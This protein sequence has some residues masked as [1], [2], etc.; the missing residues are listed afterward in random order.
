[1]SIYII[2]DLHLKAAEPE[3]FRQFSVFLQQITNKGNTLYILGDFFEY[4]VGDDANDTFYQR[5]ISLLKNATNCGLV[6]YFM[7]GNRDFLIGKTFAANSGIQLIQDPY[8][9]HWQN[10]LIALM[11][12]DL[13]CTDDQR[14]LRYRKVVQSRWFKW[15]F[16][17]LP[18]ALRNKMADKMRQKSKNRKRYEIEFDATDKGI[19]R[20][21]KDAQII[22]HGHTHKLAIHKHHSKTRYVLGDWHK[23]QYSYI[24]INDQITLYNSGVIEHA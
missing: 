11:H 17:H 3:V 18:L 9:L 23:N 13:L 24:Q 21:A 10:Q 6:I 15:L 4:W 8:Y 22:I 1:M 14:Y 2:S 16:L 12:G 5:V 19:N 7:H 20:Y